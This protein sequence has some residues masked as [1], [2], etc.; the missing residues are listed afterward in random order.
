MKQL[1]VLLLVLGSLALQGQNTA[2]WRGVNRDGIYNETG[3]IKAWPETGPAL[4]WDFSG[5]GNGY[6]SVA[7]S[8]DKIFVNGEIDSVS[9]LFAFDLSGT[10]LWKAP[11]GAEFMGEGFSGNFPGS[12]STPTVVNDLVYACSGMGRIACYETKT[13]VEKWAINMLN[14]L[15]GISNYFGYSESLLVDGNKLFC[16]PGGNDT[17]FVALDRFT[18]KILWTSKA[19]S[20]TITYCSPMLIE[21]PEIKILVSFSN[22]NLLGLNAETGELLWSHKQAVKENNHHC[23]TPIYKNG[24]IYY[25]TSYGNGLVKLALANN[26]KSIKELWRIEI[27]E[28]G[29][30]GFVIHNEKLYASTDKLRLSEIDINAGI[31]TDS[32]KV[33]TG[34]VI[35]ADSML[36]CYSDNGYVNLMGISTE[37]MELVSK[38]KVDKG[39]KEHFSHPAIKNGVLYIRHGDALMAYRIKEE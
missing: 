7:V 25:A 11:N 33:K 19:L 38:F 21:L 27:D 34:T 4:L 26:G 39:T 24:N 8:D 28:N 14:D 32:L 2:Q 13:G 29:F 12:R 22:R 20:D 9:H 1:T 17:N 3:L 16:F 15:N 6:G 36:Y 30:S 35:I 31:V 23:N 5:I 37:N 10:L 18:G